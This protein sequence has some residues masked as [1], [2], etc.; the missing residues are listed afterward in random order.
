MGNDDYFNNED[1]A[2]QL[3]S[4]VGLEFERSIKPTDIDGLLEFADV[5]FVIFE[6]KY[7]DAQM[8]SGQRL[9]LQRT[10]TAIHSSG[11]HAIAFVTRHEV[12]DPREKVIVADTIVTEYWYNGQWRKPKEEI[13]LR[14]AID[15]IRATSFQVVLPV[16]AQGICNICDCA[17]EGWENNPGRTQ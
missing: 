13:S 6:T 7:R 15:K 9:A 4:F 8:P 14:V 11:R 17:L 2:Q 16:T 1:R 3:V 12:H 10:V 5:E